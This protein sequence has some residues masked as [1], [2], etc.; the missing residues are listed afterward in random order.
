[1]AFKATFRNTIGAITVDGTYRNLQYFSKRVLSEGAVQT[2]PL[3]APMPNLWALHSPSGIMMCPA[4]VAGAGQNSPSDVWSIVGSGERYEFCDKDI[5]RATHGINIY[6]ETTG[7]LVF[8]SNIKPMRVVDMIAGVAPNLDEGFVLLDKYYDIN[9]PLNSP[10]KYAVVMG[11]IPMRF[12]AGSNINTYCPKIITEL[13][14]HVKIS[15]ELMTYRD[16][17][18]YRG[19]VQ[20]LNYSFLVVDVTGY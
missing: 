9:N 4:Y 16:A 2:L 8:S 19:T 11:S 3:S 10:K 1:M 12:S 14:S 7:K 5:I 18:R 20:T 17:G 13:N 6:S 15:M